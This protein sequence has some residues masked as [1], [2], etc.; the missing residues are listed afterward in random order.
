MIEKA[1]ALALIGLAAIVPVALVGCSSRESAS[2]SSPHEV[3]TIA[4]SIPAT[5]VDPRVTAALRTF[6]GRDANHDG[7]LTPAENAA[8][9]AQVFNAIDQ[10]GDGEI[11]AEEIDAARKALG[12]ATTP[13][14]QEVIARAD[15]D[16]DGEETLAEYI[17]QEG[18]D[19]RAADAN[20]DG[21]LSREEFLNKFMLHPAVDPAP[22]GPPPTAAPTDISSAK[23][24]SVR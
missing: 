22:P 18:R 14:S 4:P 9:A 17:A 15:Q 23:G 16:G 5:V 13:T 19:F 1:A 24:A 3:P 6:D 12:L 2:Q 10:D 20:H 11:T 21:V 8:A 7:V